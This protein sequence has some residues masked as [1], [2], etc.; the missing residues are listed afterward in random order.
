MLDKKSEILIVPKEK[1]LEPDFFEAL[2]DFQYG[3]EV[4]SEEGLKKM[5]TLA[6]AKTDDIKNN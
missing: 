2:M 6:E 1:A 5:E 3:E 4:K